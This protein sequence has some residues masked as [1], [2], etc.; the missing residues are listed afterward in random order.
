MVTILDCISCKKG[1]IKNGEVLSCG[2]P[3]DYEF[4]E[5]K[6]E[7]DDAELTSREEILGITEADE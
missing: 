1:I 3:C 2:K 6:E 7:N 5:P 4:G